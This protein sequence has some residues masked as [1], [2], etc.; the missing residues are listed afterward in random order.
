M[1]EFDTEHDLNLQ[2]SLRES[3]RYCK[4]IGSA[5]TIEDLKEYSNSLLARYIKEQLQYFP[6]GNTVT[7]TWIVNAKNIFDDVIIYD[8]ISYTDMPPL[9]QSELELQ[10]NQQVQQMFHTYKQ[11]IINS[12]FDEMKDLTNLYGIPSIEA[13][14]DVRSIED[15]LA[16][17]AY[18][19]FKQSPI[20]CIESFQ[21]QQ[22]AL[23]M[24]LSTID[25]YM[26]E[27]EFGSFC[28]SCVI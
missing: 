7:D 4:L 16:W 14:L 22:T 26:N 19:S 17:N 27:N 24:V 5:N 3:L 20:Q 23:K 9:L 6:N 2:G 13:L 10:K 18:D 12:A 15:G 25:S 21:E 1:G 8:R 11:G 28:K